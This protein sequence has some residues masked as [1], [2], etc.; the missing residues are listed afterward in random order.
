M[1]N[2]SNISISK[3][4]ALLSGVSLAALVLTGI[5]SFRIITVL[6]DHIDD[7]GTVQVTAMHEAMQADMMHDGLRAVVFRSIVAAETKDESAKQDCVGEL[8]EFSDSFNKAIDNLD[9]LALDKE[10]KTAVEEV[11]PELKKYIAESEKITNLAVSG[12]QD[13]ALAEIGEFQKTFKDL[14]GKM[15]KMG[16]LIQ[17]NSK[18]SS[19][20]AISVAL[21]AKYTV[22]AVCL[23]SFVVALAFSIFLANSIILRLRTLADI[24]ARLSA[25][26]IEEKLDCNAKDE[27]GIVARAFRDAYKYLENIADAAE[28]LS[29]G[30]FDVRLEPRSEDDKLSHNFMHV[31]ETLQEM[32]GETVQLTKGA[33]A[34][35]L[36]CRG[37]AE[38]FEG[39]YRELI[40]NI[41]HTLDSIEK[42][43]NEAGE[44]LERVANK[45]LTAEMKGEYKGDFAKIKISVNQ[46]AA[47]LEEGFRYV[48]LSAKQVADAAEQIS[49][50]SQSLAQGASEQA[51][52]LEE[53]SANLHDISARTRQNA[54]NSKEARAISSHTLT[55]AGHGMDAMK[56]LNRAVEKIKDSSDSTAKI[57][58]TIEEIAFQTNLLA[59]NAAVEAA[60]AGDAGRGFAVVAEEVRNLA[61]RS[62]EAARS[63]STMISEAVAN[64]TEGVMLN[65]EVF[66]S[67]EEI[68]SQVEKVNVVVEEIASATEMQTEGIEQIN[69]AVDQM[70]LVTQQIAANSEESASSS[71]ELSGQSQEMLGL[72]GNY[73]LKDSGFDSVGSPK[74]KRI[75]STINSNHKK[76]VV[77]TGQSIKKTQTQLPKTAMENF[78]PFDE[79]NDAIFN[80]F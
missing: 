77:N 25:K 45:D 22:I 6:S 57:V 48:A 70:N 26:N 65:A 14:E 9:T 27:I 60:R 20:S 46:A 74:P 73:K 76:T 49:Q 79:M 15:E 42:P 72:I 36:S 40:E 69:A 17:E 43:V 30:K 75:V 3:K 50:G 61:M 44:V 7:L 19:E 80:E 1:I 38:K 4:M 37:H 16:D 71:E 34:G 56:R 8:K 18:K 47:N 2:L 51:S 78:I 28:G 67:L 52:S 66:K 21:T 55:S 11:Y 33:L 10:T 58:K 53:V 39:G 5:L 24:V 64:T 41:N 12:Q 63:S 68:N 54:V 31:T 29:R 62:A 23:V 35:D 13:K 59:L 32:I